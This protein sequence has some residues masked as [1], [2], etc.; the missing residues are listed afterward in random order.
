MVGFTIFA[1]PVEV[2]DDG[3]YPDSVET[4]VLD[5][6]ELAGY[7]LVSTTAEN[8]VS[9]VACRAATIG[10]GEPICDDLSRY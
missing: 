5:V 8:T 10:C 4:H 1:G 7:T 2:G 6:I 3:R 9:G